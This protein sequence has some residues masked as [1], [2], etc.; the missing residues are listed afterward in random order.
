VSIL[1]NIFQDPVLVQRQAE[2]NA[3]WLSLNNVKTG[4]N[5]LPDSAWLEFVNDYKGWQE[6][7]DS[8]SDWSSDSKKATD[9]WQ[10]KAQDWSKRLSSYGCAGS[11]GVVTTTD[12]F[13]NPTGRETVYAGGD[14]G[15]PGVKDPPPDQQGITDKIGG[16]I[17]TAGWVAAGLV[18]LIIIGIFYVATRPTL[19]SAIGRR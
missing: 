14:Q 3:T 16:A 8:G 12:G 18:A 1:P 4:C 19:H 17:A 5:G 9:G 6:F 7:F 10:I 13:G 15:I 2:L 11:L